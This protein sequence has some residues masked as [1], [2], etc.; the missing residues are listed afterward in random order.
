MVKTSFKCQYRL[1]GLAINKGPVRVLFLSTGCLC[2][3][4]FV[5]IS[6]FFSQFPSSSPVVQSGG[7]RPPLYPLSPLPCAYCSSGPSTSCSHYSPSTHHP[8]LPLTSHAVF[9]S[10]PILGSPQTPLSTP[11][12][13]PSGAL[14]IPLFAVAMSPTVSQQ[15]GSPFTSQTNIG[16]FHATHPLPLSQVQ[17]TLYPVPNPEQELAE[18]PVQVNMCIACRECV[19]GLEVKKS[20]IN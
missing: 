14:P 16:S 8:S 6:P 12:Q 13:V 10:I 7:I 19:W 11:Q 4:F 1:Q 2:S 3:F 20:C 5:I 15:Q 18:Q 17:S 9:P